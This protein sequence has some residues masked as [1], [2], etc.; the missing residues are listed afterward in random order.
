M[1]PARQ[2]EAR[3]MSLSSNSLSERPLAWIK[4]SPKP[5]TKVP[6]SRR[7]VA[8]ADEPATPEPR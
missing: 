5:P 6:K 2:R 7:T 4:A 3:E 1:P 8:R